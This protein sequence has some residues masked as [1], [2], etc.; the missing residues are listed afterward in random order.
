MPWK[1]PSSHADQW[2]WAMRNSASD[3]SA[4][5]WNGRVRRVEF[6]GKFWRQTSSSPGCWWRGFRRPFAA[7]CGAVRAHF[8]E[9]LLDHGARFD[10]TWRLLD[11]GDQGG[12]SSESS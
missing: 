12:G 10:V 1:R 6:L 4:S 8:F 3:G 5:R 11:Q 9:Q 2:A 7:A